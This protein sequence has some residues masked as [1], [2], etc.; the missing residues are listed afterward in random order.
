MSGHEYPAVSLCMIARD[1]SRTLGP[2]LQSIRPWV[3]QIVVVDTGSTDDTPNLARSLGAEIHF[4]PWRDDFAAAR[5]ASLEHATG[6]WIFWMDSDDTIDSS[7]GRRLQA[8]V[9]QEHADSILG[10]V[11]QV[12]CPGPAGQL[13]E[14]TVVDHVKLFRRLPGLC[15]EGRIHEQIL[16][17]IRR[18]GG[19]VAWTDIFVVHSGSDQSPAGRARKH[20]RDMRILR[21]DLAERP[22]HPF[23]LFNLGMTLADLGE[24]AAAVEYFRPCL[25]LSGPDESHLRKAYALF[26]ASLM[27]LNCYDEAG[28]ICLEGRRLFPADPEL[29]FRQ[30]MIL[31]HL[32]RHADAERIYIQLLC[33]GPRREGFSSRDPSICNV[34]ARHNLAVLY[35]D[36]GQL[37]LAELQ[38]RK[39]LALEPAN[40]SA[41]QSLGQVLLKQG[42]L[43]AVRALADQARLSPALS[44][45]SQL[46]HSKIALELGDR[47]LAVELCEAALEAAPGDVDILEQL[48]RLRFEAGDAAATESNLRVLLQHDPF[49]AAAH[50]NLG[51][52]YFQLQRFPEAISHLRESI[53]LR[54]NSDSTRRQLERALEALNAPNADCELAQ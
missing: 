39:L 49:N 9:R 7:N 16:P 31:H 10:F 33:Q 27:Q 44:I 29:M 41:F 19:E 48:C 13:N 21:Q 30:A 3:D 25:A 38:W 47:D 8:L 20:E 14:M 24:H 15:F 53:G 12:H 18:Q 45:S 52:V 11:M 37:S 5:N 34:K 6:R 36:L 35:A 22:D 17:A 28:A 43:C 2:A 1:S 50:H 51:V 26:A 32:S 4:F 40:H 54:P 42:K 46:L 23:V